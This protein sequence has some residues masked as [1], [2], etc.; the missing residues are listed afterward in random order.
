MIAERDRAVVA[1][2]H[3]GPEPIWMAFEVLSQWWQRRI[4]GITAIG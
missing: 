2:S 3:R 1:V 4:T